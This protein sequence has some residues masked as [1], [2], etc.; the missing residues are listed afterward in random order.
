MRC[1]RV[2]SGKVPLLKQKACSIGMPRVS[3]L[4]FFP[5][6]KRVLSSTSTLQKSTNRIPSSGSPLPKVRNHNWQTPKFSTTVR[7]STAGGVSAA[8]S[9]ALYAVVSNPAQVAAV[10][11]DAREKNHHLKNGKGYRNPWDSFTELSAPKIVW[12]MMS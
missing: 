6:S 2:L 1:G 4:S 7:M 3:L 11:E 8:A 10:P 12:G 5:A 9:A